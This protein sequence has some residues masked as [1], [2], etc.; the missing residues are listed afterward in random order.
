MAA[1]PLRVGIYYMPINAN[2]DY[3]LIAQENSTA[4]MFSEPG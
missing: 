4:A 2:L 1:I 3:T